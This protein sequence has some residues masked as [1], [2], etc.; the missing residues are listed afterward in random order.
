MKL[1]FLSALLLASIIYSCDDT[2]DGVGDSTIAGG[3]HIA[4]GV[5][6]FQAK[7]RSI[8]ADS[9]YAKTSTAYLGKYTDPQFG[10]FTADFITQINCTDDFEFP[11]TMQEVT[12]LQLRLYFLEHFGDSLNAMRLQVDTLNTVISEKDRSTHF[13]SVD[14]T[15]YYDKTA[16]PL[17]HKAFAARGASVEDSTLVYSP[18][19]FN[20]S[21]KTIF[22]NNIKLP[23]S[24]GKFM[25]EKYKQDKKN[26]KDASAFIKNVL[27]G[28]Y[29]HCTHGDGTILYVDDIQLRMSFTYLVKRPSTG[30]IDSL[31]NGIS[32]FAA[33]KEVIQAN[34]FAN[35]DRL[36]ELAA[37]TEHTYL[38]TPAGIFTE[39][40]LPIKEISAKHLN[41][42]LNSVSITFT[43]LNEKK[44]DNNFNMGIPKH[45]LMVRK[46]DMYNF[47]EKNETF[48]GKNSFIA[49]YVDSQEKANT[50]TYPNI[51]PLVT[52]CID[53]E[54]R[55]VNDED[56][57]KVV[58]IPVSTQKDSQGNIIGLKNNLNMESSRLEGG[59]KTSIRVQVL[60][61]KF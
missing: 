49:T 21:K 57:N 54:K 17:A 1:K 25:F 39:V 15:A 11:E 24:L 2:T 44:K 59:E 5:D 8:L 20:S 9:V 51:A 48:D 36:K 46:K 30:K 12:D 34:H 22:W 33:T 55:G 3:D 40:T 6:V 37:E 47:F 52:R 53:E 61:T 16:K 38:K 45:L 10:E 56:W 43:R 31:A 4:A 19:G 41:D 60:H 23:T 58:L 28:F 26:Y 35:S 42:T 13:T 27:K 7:T 50:Y 29:V 18:D 32:V 14:P